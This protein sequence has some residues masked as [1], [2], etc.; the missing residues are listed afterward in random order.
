ML[1]VKQAS[2]AK[3]IEAIIDLRDKILRQ[4][5]GQPK[6]TATDNLE[7]TSINAYIIDETK[8]ILACGRLQEN[9]NKIGQIRFM[10]V[11]NSQQGKGL[12]K[13]IVIF[14]ESKAIELQLKKIELQAREN[15]VEFY[16]S[17]GYT[18][19][20]KSFLLWGQIQH[21]LMEKSL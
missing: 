10:A 21:Y 15:A 9:E 18:I 13:K 6:E 17:M 11:D 19:K 2:T 12:G 5:W 7:E 16:K 3:E 1:E 20:E 14:L 8:T 4:P